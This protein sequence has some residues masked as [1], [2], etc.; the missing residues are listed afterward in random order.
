VHQRVGED[1]PALGVGVGDL[2]GGAVA[3]VSTSL[4]RVAVPDGMFS[5]S[6]STAVTATGSSSCAAA[7]TTASAVAAPAMS[8][9]MV[10]IASEGFSDSPPVSKVMPLPTSATCR[11]APSGA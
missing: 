1:Q 8:I 2:D 3:G 4:T 10:I 11:S 5:A 9:F 6:A 7:L